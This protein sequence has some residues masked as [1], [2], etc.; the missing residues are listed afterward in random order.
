MVFNMNELGA[1]PDQKL[2]GSTPR[3]ISLAFF[4]FQS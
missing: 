3:D 2:Q 4:S 1:H